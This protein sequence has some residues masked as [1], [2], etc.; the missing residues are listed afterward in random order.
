LLPLLSE[1][2]CLNIA[3]SEE[4][5]EKIPGQQD[6]RLFLEYMDIMADHFG[7]VPLEANCGVQVQILEFERKF[8]ILSTYLASK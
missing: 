1:H 7:C 3:L 8:D 6:A 2:F 5:I 4:C